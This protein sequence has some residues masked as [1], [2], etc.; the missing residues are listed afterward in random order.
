LRRHILFINGILNAASRLK[1]GVEVFFPKQKAPQTE[2]PIRFFYLGGIA[3]QKG[4]HVALK[5][6]TQL[7][8]PAEFWIAGD[9]TVVE[10]VEPSIVRFLGRLSR[11]EVAQ[12]LAQVDIFLA[13]SIWYETFCF[14]LHE[15]FSAGVPAIGSNLGAIAEGI[16]HGVDGLLAE[17]NDVQSWRKAMQS[18]IDNPEQIAQF[19][20]AIERPLTQLDHAR[21]I[22]DLYQEF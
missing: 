8:G 20:T 5:A 10:T 17:P 12:T 1:P 3:P 11:A 15:A 21:Q 22:L 9:Q 16:R 14:V 19:Q 6:F 18:I 7:V 4:I 2:R 13:P